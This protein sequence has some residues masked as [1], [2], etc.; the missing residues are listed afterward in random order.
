VFAGPRYKILITACKPHAS[1]TV[2]QLSVEKTQPHD[3]HAFDNVDSPYSI[4]ILAK[5]RVLGT[6]LYSST[7]SSSSAS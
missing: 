7:F 5:P 4:R 1:T 6:S 2:M 3:D